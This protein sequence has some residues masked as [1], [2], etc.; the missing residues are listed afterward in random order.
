[1]VKDTR[2]CGFVIYK[3]IGNNSECSSFFSPG[4]W[5]LVLKLKWFPLYLVLTDNRG[6]IFSGSLESF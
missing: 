5:F 4:V 6:Q 1:M 2:G 3:N